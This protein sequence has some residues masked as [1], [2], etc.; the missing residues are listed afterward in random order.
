VKFEPIFASPIFASPILASLWFSEFERGTHGG[1]VE[2]EKR[3]FA[4]AW[5]RLL[6]LECE[7]SGFHIPRQD[8]IFEPNAAK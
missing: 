8:T 2:V 6:F 5:S 7:R 1:L 3:L 4:E